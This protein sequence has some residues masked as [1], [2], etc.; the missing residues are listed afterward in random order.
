MENPMGMPLEILNPL[1]QAAENDLEAARRKNNWAVI[2]GLIPER[3]GNR[4]CVLFGKDLM[5]GIAGFGRTPEEAMMAFDS[6]MS[7]CDGS[8]VILVR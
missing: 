8:C 3:D 7:Q 6:A 5:N 1:R 2:L 4:W